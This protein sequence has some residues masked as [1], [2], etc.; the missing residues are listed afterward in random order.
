MIAK[1]IRAGRAETGMLAQ[2]QW[3]ADNAGTLSDALAAALPG[4]ARSLLQRAA[5]PVYVPDVPGML[6]TI[7]SAHEHY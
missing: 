6:R 3:L 1:R 4:A 7:Y 5:A 2:V